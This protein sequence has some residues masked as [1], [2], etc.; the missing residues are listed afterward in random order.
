MV[1]Q[2]QKWKLKKPSSS[3]TNGDGLQTTIVGH[4]DGD[5]GSAKGNGHG[6]VQ[7]IHLD[8]DARDRGT[9]LEVHLDLDRG[10]K[11]QAVTLD[12]TETQHIPVYRPVVL[13]VKSK[14]RPG[15]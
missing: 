3:H 13:T 11:I 12:S 15:L 4:V 2:S 10:H 5:P 6:R 8:R 1:H 7:E 14:G 9:I